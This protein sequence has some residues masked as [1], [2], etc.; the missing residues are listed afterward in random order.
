MMDFRLKLLLTE[1]HFG[2]SEAP[3]QNGFSGPRVNITKMTTQDLTKIG[4]QMGFKKW[5]SLG[6]TS[7]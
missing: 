5:V 4:F 6:G 2:R 3:P 1:A 7:V